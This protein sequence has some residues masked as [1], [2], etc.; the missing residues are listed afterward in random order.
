MTTPTLHSRLDHLVVVADT[1]AQGVAWCEATLGV[2]PGPGGRHA[3]MGT[4]NRLLRIAGPQWPQAYLEI[5]AIDPSATQPP[6]EG[7]ARWFGMDQPALRAAVRSSPRLVHLVVQTDDIVR[8]VAAL[9]A[10]GEDVGAPVAASR[11]TPQG[12]LR[13]QISLRDDGC[14]QH[15]GALPALIQW[16]GPHPSAAMPDAGVRLERLVLNSVRPAA[17]REALAAIGL[18]GVTVGERSPSQGPIEADLS[19]PIGPRQLGGVPA[20]GCSDSLA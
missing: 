10:L 5:I 18:D 6:A 19:T 12:E 11:A 13:W 14:P 3:L 1:L 2:T 20:A 9:D 7:R 4:H 16:Q 15:G 17:L 8:A